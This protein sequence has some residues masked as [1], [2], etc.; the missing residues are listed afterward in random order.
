RPRRPSCLQAPTRALLLPGSRILKR[1]GMY[2]TNCRGCVIST[3]IRPVA[4]ATF[5]GRWNPRLRGVSTVEQA[6][7]ANAI[8]CDVCRSAG[9][10]GRETTQGHLWLCDDCLAQRCG[11]YCTFCGGKEGHIEIYTDWS[12]TFHM[13]AHPRCFDEQMK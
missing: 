10:K 9:A 2:M 1:F 3:A 7:L 5:F 8:T 11:M 13:S 4:S 6:M 12:D